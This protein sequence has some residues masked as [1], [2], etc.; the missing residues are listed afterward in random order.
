M[1]R[2]A[3]P[4]PP[5][6][7]PTSD[8]KA[9]TAALEASRGGGDIPDLWAPYKETFSRAQHRKCAWCE[10]EDTCEPGAVDHFAPKGEV[11]QLVEKGVEVP[12]LTNVRGR[13]VAPL[14]STGY[15]WL[16]Y[17]WDNW[18]FSCNRCNSGWKR[19]IFPVL[20]QPYPCPDPRTPYTPLLLHPFGADEPLEHLDISDLGQIEPWASSEKGRATIDTCGLDR[21]SLRGAREKRANAARKWVDLLLDQGASENQMK[22][23]WSSLLELAGDRQPYAATTRSVIRRHLKI[24]W[25]EIQDLM[26]G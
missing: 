16:A 14:H 17:A 21:E 24:S 13:G 25:A 23:A 3:R 26:A 7:F 11:G 10:A 22:H 18:L 1:I 19:T 8:I 15:W 4:E 12:C 5:D 9:A 6:G 20:E 2:Y